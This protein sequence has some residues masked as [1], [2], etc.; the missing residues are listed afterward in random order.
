M[1]VVGV[2]RRCRRSALGV[3]ARTVRRQPTSRVVRRS[4][5]GRSA[6]GRDPS[7]ATE[8]RRPCAQP[9]PP[10]GSHVGR[11]GNVRPNGRRRLLRREAQRLRRHSGPQRGDQ[12]RGLSGPHLP[13]YQGGRR[14]RFALR[15]RRCDGQPLL[16]AG[17]HDDGGRLAGGD[18]QPD[19]EDRHGDRAERRLQ[20]GE[21][22]RGARLRTGQPAPGCR[23]VGDDDARPQPLAAPAARPH[24]LAERHPDREWGAAGDRARTG[25]T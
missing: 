18:R 3:E 12:L 9:V 8:S 10:L 4:S 19:R 16:S 22:L 2:A 5:L 13:L 20:P 14:R 15:I 23:A 24:D 21:R 7:G 25:A 1:A 11:L 6:A 17:R